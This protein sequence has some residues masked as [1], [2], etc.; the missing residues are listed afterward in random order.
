MVLA[1]V[2]HLVVVHLAVPPMEVPPVVAL[3]VVQ[4]RVGRQRHPQ[5]Q[6]RPSPLVA[7]LVRQGLEALA[8]PLLQRSCV[9]QP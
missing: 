7:L 9:R 1:V 8:V 2:V 5:L 6:H 3:P 4:R